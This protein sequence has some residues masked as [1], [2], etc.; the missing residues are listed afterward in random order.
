MQ[1]ACAGLSGSSSGTTSAS[2]FLRRTRQTPQACVSALRQPGA[3]WHAAASAAHRPSRSQQARQGAAEAGRDGASAHENRRGAPVRPGAPC[4][5]PA[6]GLP[7]DPAP[8]AQRLPPVPQTR[9]SPT[10]G[11]RCRRRHAFDGGIL[12]VRMGKTKGFLEPKVS[13]AEEWADGWADGRC[14]RHGWMV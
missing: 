13:R 6:G 1:C 11:R 4:S 9:L 10:N 7:P 12:R 2:S 5:G 8:E 3:C 14:V